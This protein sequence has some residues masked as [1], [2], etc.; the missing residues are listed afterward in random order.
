M[1]HAQ[2]TIEVAR[3]LETYLFYDENEDTYVFESVDGTHFVLSTSHTQK[4]IAD[5]MRHNKLIRFMSQ[6]LKQVDY[7]L[8]A[9]VN[10]GGYFH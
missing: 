10:I 2:E 4:V 9:N 3:T 6:R 5:Y 7:G 1:N 8:S